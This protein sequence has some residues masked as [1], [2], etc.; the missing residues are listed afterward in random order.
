METG[1]W[2]FPDGEHFASSSSLYTQ[3]L[4]EDSDNSLLDMMPDDFPYDRPSHLRENADVWGTETELNGDMA[5]LPMS[6][7]PK[8]DPSC[9]EDFHKVL[10][11]WQDH[12]G[13]MQVS[14]SEDMD[15]KDIVGMDIE[16]PGNFPENLPDNIFEETSYEKEKAPSSPDNTKSV[17]R[18]FPTVSIKEEFENFSLDNFL[19]EED[20]NNGLNVV[21]D[22]VSCLQNFLEA[23]DVGSLLEQFE[24]SEKFN[25]SSPNAG[26]K[27]SV[28]DTHLFAMA[29]QQVSPKPVSAPERSL[30]TPSKLANLSHQNIRDSLPK[31]VIDRIKASGRKKV[32]PLIPAMPSKRP[33]KGATRMQDAGATL[34][35]NK[36]LKLV[37]GSS[38]GES[39]QLDHDYCTVLSGEIAPP[40]RSFYHSDATEYTGT[41]KANARRLVEHKQ[42]SVK[43]KTYSRLPEYYMALSPQKKLVSRRVGSNEEECWEKNAKKDSGLESGDMSDASEE[44][45]LSSSGVSVDTSVNQSSRHGDMQ[46]RSLLVKSTGMKEV[47]NVISFNGKD[48]PLGSVGV[49]SVNYAKLL[50]NSSSIDNL[51]NSQVK[52]KEM[53]MISVLKKCHVA[54][55]QSGVK[56]SLLVRSN[57]TNSESSLPEVIEIKEEPQEPKKRKLN[58]EQYRS[59][60][61]ELGKVYGTSSC[62]SSHNNSP[63]PSPS[64]FVV[65]SVSVG[66]ET[67]ENAG[68]DGGSSISRRSC[69]EVESYVS[70]DELREKITC[71]PSVCSVEVQTE[72]NTVEG[73]Q[74]ASEDKTV[75]RR[76]ERSPSVYVS[77]SERA[78]DRRHRQYRSRRASSSSSSASSSSSNSH[79]R[80]GAHSRRKWKRSERCSSIT[81]SVSSSGSRGRGVW[82][83]SRSRSSSSSR[84]SS[85]SSCSSDSRARSRSKV[86]RSSGRWHSRSRRSG[87]RNINWRPNNRAR[88]RSRSRSPIRSTSNNWPLSEQEKQRQVEERRVIYVGRIDEGTTKAELRRRFEAFGPIIDISVHFREHGDNYGFVTFAYKMDAYDAVEHGNDNPN[89]PKYDLCFGGRRAFCKTRYADLDGMATSSEPRSHGSSAVWELGMLNLE[90]VNPHLSGGR[91]E[92]HLGKNH[93]SSPGRDLNLDLPVFCSRAQHEWRAI[94]IKFVRRML[95]VARRNKNRN[96]V[97]Q[98]RMGLLEIVEEAR[99]MVRNGD[100]KENTK[101][102]DG[103]KSDAQLLHSELSHHYTETI[104]YA[105][106][107]LDIHEQHSSTIS[108]E[109]LVENIEKSTKSSVSNTHKVATQKQIRH[110]AQR[111]VDSDKFLAKYEELKSKNVDC[112]GSY[113]SLLSKISEDKKLREFLDRNAKQPCSDSSLNKISTCNSTQLSDTKEVDITPEEIRSRLQKV[114][115]KAQE[116]KSNPFEKRV[117][118]QSK[119][120]HP[121]H[122]SPE[123]PNWLSMRPSMSLDFVVDR[124]SAPTPFAAVLG[125]VPIG[126]QENILLE[127][128]LYCLEGVEGEYIVP[129]PLQGPY[130]PR[131]FTISSCVDAGGEQYHYNPHWPEHHVV[132]ADQS[133]RELA[134]QILPLA[135]HYSMVVRFMEEKSGFQYGQVNHALAA[136]MGC[137][138]KDYLVLVAQLE[139]LLDQGGFNLHEMWF[140][141]QP[142][143]H[144]MSILAN[145]AS[146]I[147]KAEAKGGQVLSLLH[148]QTSSYMGDTKGQELCLY[149]TQ[150]ASVPYMEILEKWIYKGAI[151]DPYQEVMEWCILN[152]GFVSGK[153]IKTPQDEDIVYTIKERQYFE[154]IEKAYLFASKTLLQL[155]MEENDLM[156]RLK[157]VKHYFL[158]DQG[159]FI[160]QFMDSCEEELSKNIGDI[161]PT[162]LESLL[163]L[164]LR[165]SAANSDPYKDDMR[166]ELLPYDLTFQMSK[167]L[168][169]ET[170]EEKGERTNKAFICVNICAHTLRAFFPHG[171]ARAFLL[172]RVWISNKVGKSFHLKNAKMYV[173]AFA[174]RQR[175]LNCIQNLEYYM[176]VEVI[177]PNWLAFLSKINN[178]NNVDEVLV[179]HSDFLDT[180]LK[181][182]MLTN[183]DLLRIV[184]S[185]MSACEQFCQ[186]MQQM[187]KYYVD[188]ELTSML[189]PGYE[190]SDTYCESPEPPT[191]TSIKECSGGSFKQR[192]N[193]FDDEFTSVLVTLLDNIS[194]LGREN[195]SEKLVNVLYR[196]NFNA[197]YTEYLEKLCADRTLAVGE[198]DHGSASG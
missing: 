59:R 114:V 157:S 152:N 178:V 47:S 197:F 16:M 21:E 153:N 105:P 52:P 39:V 103:D 113:I 85:N 26:S 41:D 132:S 72:L 95:A 84:S 191:N 150:A 74:L 88:R 93:P 181:D 161:M 134:I 43:D 169:I 68:V 29:T 44:T 158:L 129:N 106:L 125:A 91:V 94:G 81:K 135:S 19:D 182:C 118:K 120:R 32:I 69:N 12:L 1:Y 115:A 121:S 3:G 37:S 196:L 4:L 14:D 83:R 189:G 49:N 13:S 58:L 9:R 143:L 162:R 11:D 8:M 194:S 111:A 97:I 116:K 173:P 175:M 75:K 109:S 42:R 188:A 51:V 130:E 144:C 86:R 25:S 28:L 126:S 176:M 167:I 98:E 187:T 164:A 89:L 140:Y 70:K 22:E 104:S 180:C 147:N 61:K 123:L 10:C 184:N 163:E 154:S 186:F 149:L 73:D 192:I 177:E 151:C 165:T 31:E 5:V 36:L 50:N 79:R 160:M 66:T 139:M 90:E 138:I 27:P 63:V 100:R 96:E 92:N 53:T 55:I 179:C 40:P 46:G 17:E 24:A 159:D 87:H 112:L 108:P 71:P 82:S 67:G 33:G 156:R 136:A 119:A 122:H 146:T 141:V 35:R 77:R 110:L 15:V 64:P 168:S 170:Q 23:G 45:V 6:T 99:Q 38:G 183:P 166:T 127:D 30:A 18:S 34:S 102:N 193:K 128:L 198:T 76:K 48:I 117:D 80:F 190:G 185:L 56:S 145:I 65:T 20:D 171:I 78:R 174:L 62:D 155:L 142:T 54:N 195:N 2:N 148:E 57:S 137:L 124:A 133:L 60:L 7:L 131:T 107:A 172:C 101:T